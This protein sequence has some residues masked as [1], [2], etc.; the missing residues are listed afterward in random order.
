MNKLFIF[1]FQRA[2]YA[3]AV[4]HLL[5]VPALANEAQVVLHCIGLHCIPVRTALLRPE[6]Q[7]ASTSAM[8]S[9]E[10]T[11]AQLS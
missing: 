5:T 10:P 4:E 7:S 8:F 2:Y 1:S 11:S 6:P 9:L 3:K